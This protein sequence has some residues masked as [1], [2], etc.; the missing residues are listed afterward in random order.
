MVSGT[1]VSAL[2]QIFERQIVLGL[3]TINLGHADVGLRVFGIG[4]GDD[5]VLFECGVELAVVQQIFGEAANGVE[6][7]AIEN[8]GVVVRRRWR[9]CNPCAVRRLRRERHRAWRSGR[10]RESSQNFQRVRRVAFVGV[11]HGQ[12]GHGFFGTGIDLDGGLEFAFRLLHIVV[13]AV[14]AAEQQMIVDAVGIELHNLF[15]LVDGQLQ[16]VVG[17]GAAGHVAERA[18]INAAEQLV[19]FEILG[20]ALDDV[21]RFF[22]GVGDA[23]GL[24]VEFGQAGGQEFG[25]GIGFDGEAVF[26]GR[27]GGQVAA[28]VGRDHLL[29]HVRQ[30]VVVIGG[31]VIDFARRR[32]RP[33]CVGLSLESERS[34]EDGLVWLTAAVAATEIIK[35]RRKIL[36]MLDLTALEARFRN[37]SLFG[38]KAAG[39][40]VLLF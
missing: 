16:D 28:A 3:A 8:D 18:Q 14:E 11:E 35:K 22:D 30:R 13:Q 9:S 32:L 27:L 6:I 10:S 25:R 4:V 37:L 38:C 40:K 5:F 12:R 36:F 1:R 39:G 17:A 7:V 2:L 20:I 29:I 19:G 31:G 24:Y 21:L 34:T 15:V 26:L 23:A 33:A